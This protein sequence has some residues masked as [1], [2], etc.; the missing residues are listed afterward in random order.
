M[1]ETETP[2]MALAEVAA[3]LEQLAKQHQPVQLVAM[4]VLVWRPQLM[5]RQQPEPVA[6]GAAFLSVLE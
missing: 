5:A 6:V 3:A 1:A 4:A 2:E